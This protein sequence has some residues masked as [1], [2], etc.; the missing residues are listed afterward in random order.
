MRAKRSLSIAT[1]VDRHTGYQ[2]EL[3]AYNRLVVTEDRR[4]GVL[5]FNEKRPARIKGK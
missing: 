4:E 3:E 2:F 1:Q 5:A